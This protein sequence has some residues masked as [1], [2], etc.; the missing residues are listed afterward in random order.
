MLGLRG[1]HMTLLG[2]VEPGHTLQ[3]VDGRGGGEGGGNGERKPMH[4]SSQAFS[5]F[6][7][8]VLFVFQLHS[9]HTLSLFLS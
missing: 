1:D 4:A 6:I 2:L 7:I 3:E 8:C 5:H 9:L